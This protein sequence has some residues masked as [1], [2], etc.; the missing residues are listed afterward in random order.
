MADE[1]AAEAGSA[2]LRIDG[3]PPSTSSALFSATFVEAGA[4]GAL[5]AASG[6]AGGGPGGAGGPWSPLAG[7]AGAML[8]DSGLGSPGG[9]GGGGAGGAN[10]SLRFR[11]ALPTGAP[12]LVPLLRVDGALYDVSVDASARSSLARALGLFAALLAGEAEGAVAV[13]RG[14]ILPIPAFL[15]A[16]ASPA[17]AVAYFAAQPL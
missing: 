7:G 14:A 6:G 16:H 10:P 15:R 17:A 12:R 3:A 2:T 13:A 9:S 5:A 1:A 8:V 11:L 4:L